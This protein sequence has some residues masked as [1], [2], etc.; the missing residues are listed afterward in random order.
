VSRKEWVNIVAA[1][2]V[3]ALVGLLLGLVV[4]R[5]V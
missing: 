5:L 1:M 3:A 2:I 4:T